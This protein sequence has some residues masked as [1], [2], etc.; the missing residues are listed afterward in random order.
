MLGL[1]RAPMAVAPT[2][3]Y[4]MVGGRC[5]RDCAFCAQ[6]RT[7]GAGADMLSRV[8]WP[9]FPDRQVIEALQAQAGRFQRVCI[10]STAG[11][12]SFD[13]LLALV[14][15]L[16]VQ[17]S[18]PVD[19][20]VLP[21]SPQAA[22]AL[23][24]AGV[25]HIGFGVDAA[26]MSVFRAVKGPGWEQYRGLI[27][28]VAERHPGRA[29]VH[30]IAGLGESERELIQAI[31]AYADAGVTVG[32]FAFC[33]VAGTR[34]AG[35]PQPALASY[36]RVQV[37]ARLIAGGWA[38]AHDL[39]FDDQGTLAQLPDG[40]LCHLLDGKAFETS[41]CPGCNRPYY[42][43]RPGGAM[44]NYPRPLT[45]SEAREALMSTGLVQGVSGG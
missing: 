2:T 4:L 45:E 23:I 21:P 41:G 31:Q 39:G 14:E 35:H 36:R 16:R 18:L 33:P 44:Y 37:A 1:C 12:G 29:A 6:A 28:H 40:V 17:I 19:A 7:S 24:E 25:D 30:L 3:A 20:S 34:M 11:P 38:R 22:D 13:R 10:Q 26:T 9:P 42:N 8:S 27:E 15:Q 43:E 32:L 5:G